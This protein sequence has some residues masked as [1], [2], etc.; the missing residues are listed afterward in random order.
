ME[1]ALGDVTPCRKEPQQ[2]MPPGAMLGEASLAVKGLYQESM[3]LGS[4]A[5]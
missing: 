4:K 1:S 5:S 3:L 2:L